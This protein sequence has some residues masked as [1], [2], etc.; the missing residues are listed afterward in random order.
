MENRFNHQII[1]RDEALP[2][3]N[4]GMLTQ[5]D[6]ANSV[7]TVPLSSSDWQMRGLFDRQRVLEELLP[8]FIGKCLLGLAFS[9]LPFIA[10]LN[11]RRRQ[12]LLHE[13]RRRYQ[14][15]FEGTGV[16]L[17]VLDMSGLNSLFDRAQ[18]QSNEQLQ[19]WLAV[20]EQR[21]QLLQEL[22]IT[23]VNQ[24]ALQL[25]NVTTPDQAWKLLVDDNP[26]EGSAIGNQVLQAVLNQ[27]KQLELEIKL[28]DAGG[29][30]QHLWLVLRLPENPEDHN[31]VILSITDIT[32]RKLVELSLL[33]REGFWSDVVRT[34]PDHLYVQEVISQRMI[35]SNHHLGQTLGYNRAELQQMGEYF[36]EVLLHPDDADFYRRSRQTQRQAG[37]RQLMQ[38]QLR[39]RHR[40]GQWRR[41]EIR[42]QALARDKHDQVTR[43][44]GVAK[45]ITDQLEASESLRDSEQR[46][47]MLA[48]S[49]SDVIFSTDSRLVLNYVSPSVHA[50]LGYDVE[51]IFQNGWQSTIA[52]PQ[53]LAGIFNLMDRVSKALDKP[54]QLALLRSQVQT[55]LFLFDCLRADGRKIPIELRLVLVWDEHGAFEGVLGVGRDISQQRRAEKDLRMAAT[56]FE[57]STSA[58]LITDPAGYIVQANEAFSRVSG[59]AVEQVLDQL[60]NMLTVDEQQEAHLRYVL[61]QLSQHSTWEGEVWLKRRNGEHYPAWVGITA[62]LDDEG[63]L[64]SYVCFF[65]DI[66]ERK[67]SE[68]R[69]HRLAYY[70]A[71]THLPNRTLFQD[72]LHT[73]LQAAERQSPGW[74]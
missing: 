36:W 64:A 54:D 4:P 7:L 53:Q 2:L 41:F 63:D 5:D 34:V 43:I 74:C 16:A 72:R 25:L 51:W 69:I 45:D 70:D 52:N 50:V 18:L 44:I 57:H 73:A 32:S 13:G 68:Q 12:R 21:Q 14:E 60:P 33:E 27:Q 42:E 48:E 26:L 10:L 28:Q 66:S 47:R 3:I 24:V 29:R 67:A 39:F 23:E 49:I 1:S 8:A 40:N 11:M 46:Y 22:R 20:P 58:I 55:Q 62:V 59:Y 17:C 65:T 6:L 61:K 19:A 71:L 31:A 9:M 37:Y 38:C 56:V 35:F 30:D 15:I